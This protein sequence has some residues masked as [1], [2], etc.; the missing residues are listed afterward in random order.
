MDT[1]SVDE[2]VKGE[3]VNE[4]QHFLILRTSSVGN[5]DRQCFWKERLSFQV[6]RVFRLTEWHSPGAKPRCRWVSYRRLHP[7]NY[8]TRL[9]EW[10]HVYCLITEGHLLL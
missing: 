10:G 3:Q 1:L 8:R 6:I 2:D 5:C 4:I 9:S 7:E